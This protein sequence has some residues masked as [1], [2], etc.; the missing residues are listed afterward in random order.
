MDYVCRKSTKPGAY[1]CTKTRY[2]DDEIKADLHVMDEGLHH[3]VWDAGH[4]PVGDVPCIRTANQICALAV[5]GTPVF[6]AVAACH[7]HLP[8]MR[9]W[10]V[11]D[12][13]WRLVAM[14]QDISW[15][16]DGA[17]FNRYRLTFTE[18]A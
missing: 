18:E 3:T 14:R 9:L 13:V 8:L 10:N 1:D 2:T 12:T 7:P 6:E 17:E 15:W 11:D 5:K 16:R 4:L